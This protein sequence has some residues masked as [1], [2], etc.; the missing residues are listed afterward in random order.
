MIFCDREGNVMNS[1]KRPGRLQPANHAADSIHSHCPMILVTLKS[2]VSTYSPL[3]ALSVGNGGTSI[4]VTRA[5]DVHFEPSLPRLLH[6]SISSPPYLPAPTLPPFP[7]IS[8]AWFSV[9]PHLHLHGLPNRPICLLH[10]S[11]SI[12]IN[13]PHRGDVPVSV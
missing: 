11:L 12:S 3:V 4:W 8:R 6:S 2:T 10:Q 9:I 7:Q 13:T 1:A 5:S